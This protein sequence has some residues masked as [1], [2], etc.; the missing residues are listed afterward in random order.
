ME[1]ETVEN[2]SP[3]TLR[4]YDPV[5]LAGQA[6]L[7]QM[8]SGGYVEA[9]RGLDR[10][11]WRAADAAEKTA[12]QVWGKAC[13]KPPMAVQM[14]RVQRRNT[15]HSLVLS[16]RQEESVDDTKAIKEPGAHAIRAMHDDKKQGVA[17]GRMT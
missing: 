8:F 1:V 13:G 2:H 14:L 16:R 15:G 11:S 17:M 12:F 5:R 10:R 4:F 7:P 3:P 9:A 6:A